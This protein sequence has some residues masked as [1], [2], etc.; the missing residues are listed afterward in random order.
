MTTYGTS[1]MQDVRSELRSLRRLLLEAENATLR[2]RVQALTEQMDDLAELVVRY[3]IAYD[4]KRVD[5]N[6]LE[7]EVGSAQRKI[8]QLSIQREQIARR[9]MEVI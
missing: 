1:P 7:R 4:Q 2:A 8:R 6:T 3:A 5:Y 9:F